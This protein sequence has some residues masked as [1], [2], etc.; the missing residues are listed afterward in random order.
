MGLPFGYSQGNRSEYLAIPALTKLGFTVPVPRQEDDFGLDFIVHLAEVE[1]NVLIPTGKP[2][3]IQIKSNKEPI[4]FEEQPERDC[5]SCSSL[6]L[7][8]GVVS[9]KELTLQVY[10]TIRRVQAYWH[11]GDGRKTRLV[12]DEGQRGMIPDIQHDEQDTV[13]IPT[14]PPILKIHM[15]E[16]ADPNERLA[17]RQLL[18]RVMRSW[19]DLENENMSLRSQEVPVFF[20]PTHY[21][22]DNPLTENTPRGHSLFASEGSL[23]NALKATRKV[24]ESLS[25]YLTRLSG[26]T[27]TK[28]AVCTTV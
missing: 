21:T 11:Y 2:F 14:G 23:P 1:N 18:Q 17:E 25:F 8:L 19:L 20:W 15:G 3:G 4:V 27:P 12:F 16:P 7:F 5:L 22:T 10:N 9:R 13:T 26:R 28:K 24:L 6:P